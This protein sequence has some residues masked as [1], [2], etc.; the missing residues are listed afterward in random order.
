MIFNVGSSGIQF[1]NT[2]LSL[3]KKVTT[4]QRESIEGPTIV[5]DTELGEHFFI[6]LGVSHKIN[7]LGPRSLK[8]D[9][10]IYISED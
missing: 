7:V 2:F 5:F 10:D 9:R 3:A 8:D 6:D 4:N 1:V